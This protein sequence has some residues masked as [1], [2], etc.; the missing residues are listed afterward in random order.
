MYVTILDLLGL[1]VLAIFIASGF[2]MGL[3]EVI[4]SLAGLVLGT[5]VAGVFYRDFGGWMGNALFGSENVGYVVAFIIIFIIVSK[6]IGIVFYILSKILKIGMI[7][8]FMKSINRFGGAV[9]GA[10][11][12]V[13]VVGLV[14]LFVAQFPFSFWLDGQ[15]ASSKIVI[16]FMAAAKILTPLLPKLIIHTL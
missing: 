9:L 4:G 5:W 1:M 8:P 6:L 15:L 12:G 14:L 7:I 2:F 13:F 11:E 16:W 3:I 10:I